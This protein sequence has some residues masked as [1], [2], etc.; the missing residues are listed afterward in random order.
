M[1]S[2]LLEEDKL[3]KLYNVEKPVVPDISYIDT[4]KEEDIFISK[5]PVKDYPIYLQ[6]TKDRNKETTLIVELMRE[7]FV[8][9]ASKGRKTISYDLFPFNFY[10]VYDVRYEYDNNLKRNVPKSVRD[11]E[12]GKSI[13]IDGLE[14][15]NFKY[16]ATLDEH[17]LR[18]IRLAVKSS[19]KQKYINT[20]LE[21]FKG[22][23]PFLVPGNYISTYQNPLANKVNYGYSLFNNIFRNLFFPVYKYKYFIRLQNTVV[24]NKNE[25]LNRDDKILFNILP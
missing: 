16:I 18:G 15:N 14:S 20:K 1:S 19:D 7:E 21:P 12:F 4:T 24:D 5:T 10:I 13:K 9:N 8:N 6:K 22:L 25:D 2:E 11:Q 17:S 23:S 3:V